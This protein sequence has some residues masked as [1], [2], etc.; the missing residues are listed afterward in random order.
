M[1]QDIDITLLIRS[2]IEKVKEKVGRAHVEQPN[3][4]YRR[5]IHLPGQTKGVGE[6]SSILVRGRKNRAGR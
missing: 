5:G 4:I 6:P 3:Q 2:V 1:K